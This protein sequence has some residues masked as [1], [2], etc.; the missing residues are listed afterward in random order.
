MSNYVTLAIDG[1]DNY[2]RKDMMGAIRE[3]DTV[4]F[5][6]DGVLI[7][8]TDA[9]G[10]A[11]EEA[12]SYISSLLLGAQIPDGVI[13]SDVI[14]A[15][16]KT[17][18]FNND[19]ALT[20]AVLMYI[21]NSLTPEEKMMVEG[22]V[23]ES[24][25]YD[26][27]ESKME[28][29]RNTR[30]QLSI[31]TFHSLRQELL[32]FAGKLDETGNVLVDA[33]LIN[34]SEPV[35]SFLGFPG[36]VGQDLI[37]TIFELLFDGSDLFEDTFETTPLFQTERALVDEGKIIIKTE[38][39]TETSEIIGTKNYGIAS[40]S[41]EN[42]AKHVLGPVKELFKEEAQVWMDDVLSYMGGQPETNLQKPD[43][44]SLVKAAEGFEPFKKAVYVGDT[45]ADLYTVRNTQKGDQRYMFMGVYQHGF[46]G[47][48][49]VSLFIE[50]NATIVAANVNMLPPI[51]RYV[52]NSS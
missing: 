20:Y 19:W 11:V 4:I 36:K 1:Y 45:M 22:I 32:V 31:G 24:M 10:K 47:D 3:V 7:D 6:C 13:D 21:L 12:V 2:I 51:L 26:T 14:S 27:L 42:T 16:K 17:G 34:V 37:P 52:R 25:G 49:T 50:H 5:D 40:G 29:V 18:G 30:E 43:P 46:P 44:Y 15:F 38:T 35:R 8:V 48:N 41:I 9:Y 33:L 28:Q 39:L 23:E